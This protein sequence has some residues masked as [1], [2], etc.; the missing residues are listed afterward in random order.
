MCKISTEYYKTGY[1]E[2]T[3]N[4]GCVVHQKW[5]ATFSTMAY[6]VHHVNCYLYSKQNADILRYYPENYG[7]L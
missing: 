6:N 4:Y 7:P 5:G 3:Q 2:I 1:A